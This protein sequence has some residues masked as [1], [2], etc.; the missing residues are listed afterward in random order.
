MVMAEAFEP[1]KAYRE[2]T[3]EDCFASDQA[4]KLVTLVNGAIAG[5][6]ATKSDLE[7]LQSVLEAKMDAWNKDYVGKMAKFR[8]QVILWVLGGTGVMLFAKDL[9]LPLQ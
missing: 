3:D 9:L 5:N 7:N 4:E 6:V 2:L 8:L 1:H